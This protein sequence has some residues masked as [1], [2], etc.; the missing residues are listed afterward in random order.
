MMIPAHELIAYRDSMMATPGA[1][2]NTFKF[3]KAMYA[4][5]K[6]RGHCPHSPAAGIKVDY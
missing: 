1:A 3:I 4:W 2:H 5:A 6:E